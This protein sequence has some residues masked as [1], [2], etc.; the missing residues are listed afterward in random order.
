MPEGTGLAKLRRQAFA[1]TQEGMS[2]VNCGARLT[3]GYMLVDKLSKG[4]VC[5]HLSV[6]TRR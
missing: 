2:R 6:G 1:C 4:Y 5:L 3:D